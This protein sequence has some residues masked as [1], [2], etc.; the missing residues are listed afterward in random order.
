MELQ[1][2]N[3]RQR[4]K[5]TIDAI[6]KGS[7]TIGFIGGSITDAR[8]RN[9]WP[10]PVI[11]WFADNFP[12]TRITIENAAIGAT[13]SDLAVFR[14]ERD[15][16]EREC[17]LIFVEYAVNDNDEPVEKRMRTREGLLRK[18]LASPK[19]DLVLT[20]TYS[21]DMYEDMINDRIPQSVNDFE[22]LAQHYNIGSV[23]M[24]LYALN[25]VKRGLIR[26]EEWLPDGLHPESRGSYV[27]GQS[28]IKFLEEELLS[29]ANEYIENTNDHMPASYNKNNW[30]KCYKLSFS[31]VNL[32]GPWVIRR[33]TS[34]QWIDQ[35][36]ETSS[37]GAEL[38]FL[39]NGRG[40]V[41]GFDFG[42]TSAEFIYRLDGGEWTEVKRDRPD[43]CGDE[44]WYRVTYI[45]DDL[46][47]I[48][49]KFELKVIHGNRDECKGTNFRLAMI[50]IV[51]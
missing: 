16:I 41:L 13:G 38:S 10:E 31:K 17:D 30:E 51:P 4:L 45:C 9:R 20:Y 6:K 36:I 3:H 42:K 44:G 33:C 15:L 46:K 27:Y 26:W 19:S 37:V 1:V 28:V 48:E 29:K 14:A 47:D 21:M 24:G 23:W 32:K 34:L 39:F 2:F 12:D 43:W 11:A 49:H 35:V 40:L 18:L 5:R 22:I 7:L 8:G 25:E 50:G